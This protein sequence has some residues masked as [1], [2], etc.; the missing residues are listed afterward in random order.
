[1][2]KKVEA[3]FLWTIGASL[4]YGAIAVFYYGFYVLF[5]AG[6]LVE[7][8]VGEYRQMPSFGPGLAWMILSVIMVFVGKAIL[9]K[10]KEIEK[11]LTYEKSRREKETLIKETLKNKIAPFHADESREE[12]RENRFVENDPEIDFETI[13]FLLEPTSGHR[14]NSFEEDES[15]YDIDTIDLSLGLLSMDRANG[16]DEDDTDLG[17][18]TANQTLEYKSPDPK[19]NLDEDDTELEYPE[20]E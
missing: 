13:D 9:T 19:R 7:V 17:L 10:E 15:K 6:P 1:M 2:L 8:Y 3:V 12:L 18:A 20:E 4:I 16:F 5:L 11:E 14:A